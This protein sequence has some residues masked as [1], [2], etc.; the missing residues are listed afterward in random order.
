MERERER[1]K[2]R[3]WE[4]DPTRYVSCVPRGHIKIPTI[5]FHFIP[6]IHNS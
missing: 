5:T 3:E 1:E 2:V 6:S 4:R